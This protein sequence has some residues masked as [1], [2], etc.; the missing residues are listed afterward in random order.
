MNALIIFAKSPDINTVKTR[1]KGYIPDTERLSLYIRLMDN[2]INVS[3]K[4]KDVTAFIAYTPQGE[5]FKKY[6]L[7]IFPQ[8][9]IDLGN[10]MYNAFKHVFSSGYRKAVII[11][12]DIPE[13]N[14]N[15]ISDAF[16]LLD[17]FDIVLGPAKDGGYY[18]IGMKKAEKNIFKS[19]RWSTDKVL[20]ETLNK[21]EEV[22]M[23]VS[24]VK[25]LRDIDRVED[26]KS[27]IFS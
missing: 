16:I 12:T 21:I 23:T 8:K 3:G 22:G 24:Y 2:T 1:L 18:L 9:G 10:R 26:I 20:K 25:T 14:D 11:G 15:I 4:V 27:S 13:I 6:D 19:I 5:Y 17:N 7:P